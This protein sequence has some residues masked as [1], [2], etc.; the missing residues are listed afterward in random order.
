MIDRATPLSTQGLPLRARGGTGP[1]RFTVD[2]G[3]DCRTAGD[4]AG[5]G[6]SASRTRSAPGLAAAPGPPP[7]VRARRHG[8]HPLHLVLGAVGEGSPAR[9]PLRAGAPHGPAAHDHRRRGWDA[10]MRGCSASR[11]PS[12]AA[13]PTRSPSAPGPAICWPRSSARWC[14]APAA[15]DRHRGRDPRRPQPLGPDL[16]ARRPRPRAPRRHDPRRR[17]HQ[18]PLDDRPAL[19]GVGAVGADP[20]RRHRRPRR[21][22]RHRRRRLRRGVLAPRHRRRPRA[23]HAARHDR[24]AVGGRRA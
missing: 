11:C 14:P 12:T 16:P 20:Q 23:H 7:G 9:S 18:G 3:G 4:G 15:R 17:G 10:T 24:R 21:R 22:A 8:P 2:G 5:G 19:L 1:Y 6:S 13:A